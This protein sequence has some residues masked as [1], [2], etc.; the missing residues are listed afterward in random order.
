MALF[1]EQADYIEFINL[2]HNALQLSRM[3]LLGY[4]LMTN[5]YHLI[6]D[7]S[8]AQ[9]KRCMHFLN[10][11]YSRY[12]NR[13]YEL[14]GHAFDGPY[15]AYLQHTPLFLVRRLAYVF[16]NP[17]AARMVQEPQEY[18]WSG[19]LSFMG[20]TGSPLP[21]EWWRALRHLDADPAKARALFREILMREASRPKRVL[22]EVPTAMDLQRDQ[23]RWLLE[24]AQHR[25]S[26]MVALNSQE[27]AIAWGHRAGIP[28][29][30][31]ALELGQDSSD[32]VYLVLK[33]LRRRQERGTLVIP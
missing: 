9:L 8:S 27:L 3:A 18:A 33:N 31:M 16:L 17:V 11:R 4:V 10:R 13:K 26:G 2:L 25:N 19:Y 29:R 15:K 6:L 7:G 21:V 32:E 12:H 1:H 20:M 22:P 5:H 14:D 28:P 23:F 30:A 24:E